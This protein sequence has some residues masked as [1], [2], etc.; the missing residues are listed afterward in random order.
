MKKELRCLNSLVWLL[1]L[2]G[3]LIFT[4]S[5]YAHVQQGQAVSFMT[6][7]EHPWSGLDHILAMVAVGLWGAQLGN[8]A[9]WILPITFP[10]VMSLG[11]MMGLVG[12]P[13]PGIE[14]GIAVS[15]IVLGIMV[16]GEVRPKLIV[17]AI[18]VGC[19]AVFHGHAHGTELPTGQN[20]LLYS[21]GFVFA[22]GC[23]HAIGV[24]I[25]LIHRWPLGKLA[26]RGSGGLIAAMGIFFLWQ[27]V[28]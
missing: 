2:A 8:P 4:P 23:L 26:L 6:G 7:L 21:M 27:V 25:G 1:V 11:A 16:L 18:L 22:T 3:Y 12:I 20:G 15:A 24:G 5:A 28:A 19:F 14:I 13:L 10:L 17:A 9:I